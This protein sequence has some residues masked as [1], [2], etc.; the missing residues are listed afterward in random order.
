MGSSLSVSCFIFAFA[1]LG[2]ALYLYPRFGREFVPVMDEGAFNMNIQLF[3]AISSEQAMAMSA[4]LE[5]KLKEFPELDVIFSRT[6]QIGVAVEARGV[7]T[8]RN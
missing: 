3:P 7:E 2:N 1:L 5:K 8:N 4:L 6:G